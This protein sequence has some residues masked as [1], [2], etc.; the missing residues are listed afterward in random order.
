M[1]HV[2]R[3]LLVLSF[4]AI[5]GQPAAAQALNRVL[6]T[7]ITCLDL[8]GAYVLSQ[9]ATPVYLGFFGNQFATESIMNQFGT[10]GSQFSSVSVRNTIGNYG[11]PVGTYSANNNITSKPPAIGKNGVLLG[12]LTTNPV[13]TGGISLATIDASC[14]FFSTAPVVNTSP[15]AAPASVR[16]SDGLYTDAIEVTWDS[17]PS[18]TNYIVLRAEAMEATPEPIGS[19]SDTVFPVFEGEP[20]KLYWF[21]VAASN[22]AG[23]SILSEPDSGFIMDELDTF[24]LSVQ[25]SG[26]GSGRVSSSSGGIDCGP[27][28]TAEYSEGTVVTLTVTSGIGSTFTGWSGACSGTADCIVTMDSDKVVTAGYKKDDDPPGDQLSSIYIPFIVR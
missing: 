26:D 5:P 28:C 18:A 17:V 4:L 7:D 22:S 13:V 8:D 27:T 3:T 19:T 23:Q 6:N 25:K 16:A 2:F 14:T 15:P 12:Y 10:Y 9:E 24:M 20:G 11:S 1:L 21:W